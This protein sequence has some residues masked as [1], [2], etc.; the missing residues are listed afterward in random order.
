MREFKKTTWKEW[1]EDVS[2][3]MKED[4]MLASSGKEPSPGLTFDWDNDENDYVATGHL[5]KK[6][7]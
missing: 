7:H 6:I 1:V 5:N 4:P 3:E 2:Q